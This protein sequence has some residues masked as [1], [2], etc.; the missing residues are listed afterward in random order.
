V[1]ADSVEHLIVIGGSSGALDV[2]AEIVGAL[3][4]T[5]PAPVCV[6]VH[7]SP[8]SPGVLDRMIARAGA[9]PAKTVPGREWLVN[10]QVY[11]AAPDHHLLVEPGRVMLGNGPRENLARPA[12]DPLFRSAA[13]VYG[14]RV[15][16]VLLSGSLDDGTSGLHT[17]KQLGGVAIVQDPDD[18]RF[19]AMP[20]HALRHVRVDHRLPA[21]AIGP[22]L[23]RL[24]AGR[25]ADRMRQAPRDLGVEVAIAKG[26][27]ALEAGVERLG[28]PSPY[29]CPDCHG[30]LMRLKDE[31]RLRFRCHT[32]H[33]FSAATLVGVVRRGMDDAVW[34]A[35]RALEEGGR[36]LRDLSSHAARDE[37]QSLERA[38]ALAFADADAL[39]AVSER[40]L[41][42]LERS[43]AGT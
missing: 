2:L 7:T 10:G 13:Q 35:I 39:R 40:D 15:I 1:P 32:G 37:R 24:T 30:V 42:S 31:P 28:P 11:V 17:V 16:G 18:A 26:Q 8:D 36:L 34:N 14:P 38:A 3:P 43:A 5:F 19:P 29:T 27:N 12:I 6:V 20:A 25:V 41:V 9:L 4:A 21:R 23:V 33:A 22:E